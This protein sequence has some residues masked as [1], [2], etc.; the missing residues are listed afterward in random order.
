MRTPNASRRL[1]T[2][3]IN[4]HDPAIT[5]VG[6]PV[7]AECTWAHQCQMHGVTKSACSPGPGAVFMTRGGL[8]AQSLTRLPPP[9]TTAADLARVMVL[10]DTIAIVR[11]VVSH[12]VFVASSHNAC[13]H[14]DFDGGA[15][16]TA[17]A[18][19]TRQTS[20]L[21][22][23]H[24]RDSVWIDTSFSLHPILHKHANDCWSLQLHTFCE[25][26]TVS[27]RPALVSCAAT[28]RLVYVQ[29]TPDLY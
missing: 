22:C 21:R 19:P 4:E 1:S 29:E 25:I 12:L 14:S 27:R 17:D 16:G 15:D 5:E 11:S 9:R 8:V 18:L 13:S 24:A 23:W 6:N 28:V 7:R 10:L 2:A 3:T 26:H 20:K